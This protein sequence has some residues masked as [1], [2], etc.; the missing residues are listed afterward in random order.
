MLKVVEVARQAVSSEDYAVIIKHITALKD[1]ITVHKPTGKDLQDINDTV[2]YL[3]H[4]TVQEQNR[5]DSIAKKSDDYDKVRAKLEEIDELFGFY[6]KIINDP[7]IAGYQYGDSSITTDTALKAKQQIVDTIIQRF[8]DIMGVKPDGS[9]A[10]P[11]SKHIHGAPPAVPETLGTKLTDL[12][13]EFARLEKEMDR[14]AFEINKENGVYDEKISTQ[15]LARAQELAAEKKR[16]EEK[17]K[18]RDDLR[19]IPSITPTDYISRDDKLNLAKINADIKT[20]RKKKGKTPDEIRLLDILT[21]LQRLPETRETFDPAKETELSDIYS[22]YGVSS[23]EEL[24]TVLSQHEVEN[25]PDAG[26]EDDGITPADLANRDSTVTPAE[27]KRVIGRPLPADVVGETLDDATIY[28]RQ[29]GFAPCVNKNSFIY[30]RPVFKKDHFWSKPKVESMQLVEESIESLLKHPAA[31]YEK[32][33]NEL[34]AR[35]KNLPGG[36]II[37]VNDINNMIA[38]FNKLLRAGRYDE[39]IKRIIATKSTISRTDLANFVVD[40][41]L[42]VDRSGKPR[43]VAFPGGDENYHAPHVKAKDRAILS[44][45]RLFSPTVMDTLDPDTPNDTITTERNDKYLRYQPANR[46]TGPVVSRNVVH[47]RTHHKD[48]RDER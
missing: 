5:R 28:L 30:A 21:K 29:Q 39:A 25:A 35:A 26:H 17:N 14:L 10:F 43:T 48:D 37:S 31:A 47:D 46:G 33:L 18:P 7:D 22:K 23:I 9:K 20:L 15:D 42:L 1:Y 2:T 8:S 38:T 6:K 27:G 44:P 11:I 41:T 3:E 24:T 36:P 16:I 13:T 40:H 32:A 12:M 45:L 19:T 34:Q 4:V